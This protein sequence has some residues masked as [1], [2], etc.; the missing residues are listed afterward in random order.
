MFFHHLGVR[1]MKNG[2]RKFRVIVEVTMDFPSSEREATKVLGALLRD[3][4]TPLERWKIT[5]AVAKEY[6]RALP[7]R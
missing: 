4:D 2:K 3:L 5:K 6:G 7:N 1:G